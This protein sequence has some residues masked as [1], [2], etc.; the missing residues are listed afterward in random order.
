MARDC[1]S[2]DMRYTVDYYKGDKGLGGAGDRTGHARFDHLRTLFG[3]KFT[4]VASAAAWQ[5]SAQACVSGC[6]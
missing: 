5:G 6:R 1:K 4:G 2:K 3:E